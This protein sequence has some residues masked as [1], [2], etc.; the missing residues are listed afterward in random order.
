MSFPFLCNI[1]GQIRIKEK[2]ISYIGVHSHVLVHIGEIWD[3]VDKDMGNEVVEVERGIL[4]R[5]F[6]RP[7]STLVDSLAIVLRDS[8]HLGLISV[9]FAVKGQDFESI[10][11]KGESSNLENS[12]K[13]IDMQVKRLQLRAC[14][15]EHG[16]WR[17]VDKLEGCVLH[18]LK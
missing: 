8:E 3:L 14:D 12:L 16:A 7:K 5:F 13:D 2:S 4:I 1:A 11:F 17:E 9:F 18:L 6:D 15:P 10:L